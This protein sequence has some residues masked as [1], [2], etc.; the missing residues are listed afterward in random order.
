MG[1]FVYNDGMHLFDTLV[2]RW[3]RMPYTLVA[4]VAHP[5][6]RQTVV[7]LHGIGNTHEAWQPVIKK[8]PKDIRIVS[9]D[10]LG[11]G[12]SAKPTWA[13]YN[14]R[15]Q[16]RSLQATLLSLGIVGKVTL[17]GHSLGSLVAIEFARR[18][19]LQVKQLLLCSPP[20]Y[21]MEEVSGFAPSP[22]R[23]LR[24]IYKLA[25]QNK[26]QFMD[27]AMLVK[28]YKLANPSLTITKETIDSYM[29]TLQAMIINQTALHDV[30]KLKMPIH[31]MRG[32]LDPFVIATHIA[33]LKKQRS[34]ITTQTVAAGHEVLGLY[35]S[36]V[37]DK[38]TDMVGSKL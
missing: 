14:A 8:L 2:H 10:L 30:S 27:L 13:T 36:A 19:P 16:A 23:A 15:T 22:D 38:V 12:K 5:K 28:H 25:L 9:V 11:F 4:E 37:A 24:R 21:Q 20:L 29:A 1:V 7:L 33:D 31:I 6:A 35:A 17:V 34:N 26:D 3:L 32:A 18:Y